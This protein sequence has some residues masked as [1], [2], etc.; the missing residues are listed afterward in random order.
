MEA[1]MNEKRPMSLDLEVEEIE[2]REL[3]SATYCS[4]STTSSRC[5]CLCIPRT[6]IV[7][8]PRS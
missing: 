4:S 3:G 2:R 7:C 1:E 8:D 6:T 5:T